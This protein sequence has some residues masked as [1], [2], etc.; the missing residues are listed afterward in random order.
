MSPAKL[1]ILIVNYNGRAYLSECLDSV[2]RHAPS[3]TEVIVTDNGSTDGSAELV[4]R[5]YAWVRLIRCERN[6]GFAGGNNMAGRKAT[7]DIVLLLNPDTILLEDLHPAIDAIRGDSGI[8]ALTIRALYRDGTNQP[9]V[10]RFPTPARLA[11]LANLFT[12]T[13]EVCSP[14]EV[15]WAQASFLLVRRAA[16]EKLGGLDE[17]F[18]MYA[19]DLDFCKR[20]KD[21]GLKVVYLPH[22]SY[23]HLGGF[24]RSRFPMLIAGIRKYVDKHF[25]G[26]RWIAA[27][28]ILLVGCAYRLS[29]A[30]ARVVA[31]PS[32][33]N[34]TFVRIAAYAFRHA[35]A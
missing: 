28:A 27:R 4:E 11:R 25:H 30:V 33:A 10:G 3:S 14:V 18:F 34:R 6:L 5:N 2:R 8:G 1:S 26:S 17:R 19:E 9:C 32:L 23:V 29:V 20:T 13:D 7:G 21:L 31:A 24:D 35:L 16:W 12:Q 22:V 15:D